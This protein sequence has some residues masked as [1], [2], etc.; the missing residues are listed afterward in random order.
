MKKFVKSGAFKIII[1]LIALCVGMMI[2][3]YTRGGYT[4]NGEGILN[5]VLNPFRKIGNGIST[6]FSDGVNRVS[7]D[8]SLYDENKELKKEISKYKQMEA[9]YNK[10]KDDLDELKAF[11]DIKKEHDDYKLSS[12]CS[13]IGYVANDTSDTFYIDKGTD[14]GIK[15][16]DPVVVSEGLV[17]LVTK[18]YKSYSTVTTVL[19]DDI[20]VSASISG[21]KDTGSVKGSTDLAKQKLTKMS[22]LDK[23]SSKAA[24]GDLVVTSPKSGIFPS[25]Y[26]IGTISDLKM[27]DNG[28][29][30]DAIIQPAVDVS[31]LE[32]VMV[33]LDF[34]GKGKTDDEKPEKDS[35]GDGETTEES[36]QVTTKR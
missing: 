13:V 20:S 22:H 35:T 32:K 24:V 2:Y 5:T 17:G 4:L 18:V 10:T 19:S 36:S 11:M 25:G 6:S 31:D 12:P 7:S 21:K 15:L 27:S 23:D 33:I 3:A 26:L 29:S 34:D 14:D 16:Y 8:N 1:A 30:N 28:L 9:D